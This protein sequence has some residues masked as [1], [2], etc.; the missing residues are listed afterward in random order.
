MVG[1]TDLISGIQPKTRPRKPKTLSWGNL[2]CKSAYWP[3][4]FRTTDLAIVDCWTTVSESAEIESHMC[5]VELFSRMPKPSSWSLL[6]VCITVS[7]GCLVFNLML[8][9]PFFFLALGCWNRQLWCNYSVTAHYVVLWNTFYLFEI[10]HTVSKYPHLHFVVT[11][12]Q[13]FP[14]LICRTIAGPTLAVQV[15][16]GSPVMSSYCATLLWSD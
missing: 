16:F 5:S 15:C 3:L 4:G 7:R 11:H 13:I 14:C 6:T 9:V 10:F 8:L 2:K 12:K 1:T